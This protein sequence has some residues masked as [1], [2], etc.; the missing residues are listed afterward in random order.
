[1]NYVNCELE[2]LYYHLWLK[3]G[4]TAPK[5]TFTIPETIFYRH[6]K[7]ET[8]YFTSKEGYILKKNKYNVSSKSIHHKF[9]KNLQ[10]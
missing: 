10:P 2:W 3:T 4:Q 9:T 8:W 7:P 6:G 1:M 5:F